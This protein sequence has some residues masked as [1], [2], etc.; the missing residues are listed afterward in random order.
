MEFNI[1]K[2]VR[3]NQKFHIEDV[4]SVRIG[5]SFQ[6]INIGDFCNE[7]G[8]CSTFCPT[9]G[10]PYRIKPKFYLQTESFQN[11]AFGYMLDDGVLHARMDGEKETL[12]QQGRR[13]IYETRDVQAH[14]NSKTFAVEEITFSAGAPDTIELRHAARMCVLMTALKDFYIYN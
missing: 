3:Q 8:N 7:C 10:E 1:Q 11:E 9:S 4:E 14:M 12:S 2:A 6:I 13:L 5:Q